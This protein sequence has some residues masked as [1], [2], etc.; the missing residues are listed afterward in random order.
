MA[1]PKDSA[2]SV[3]YMPIIKL[4]VSTVAFLVL[5]YELS[6]LNSADPVSL[7]YKRS[8]LVEKGVQS[9]T[10][11]QVDSVEFTIIAPQC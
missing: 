10:E 3:V 7:R 1:G 11:M 2:D 6:Y 4:H 5:L 8:R 9:E